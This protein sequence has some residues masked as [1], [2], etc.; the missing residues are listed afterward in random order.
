MP[1]GQPNGIASMSATAAL[2]RITSYA[3]AQ[4]S[5]HVAGTIVNGK[6]RIEL[7]VDA[8]RTSGQGSL[9][10]NGGRTDIRVVHGVLYDR[11][12]AKTL[13]AHGVP[14]RQAR[15]AAGKWNAERLTAGSS[16]AASTADLVLLPQLFAQVLKPSGTIV[17][18][19][20]V[21]LAGAAAYYLVDN[22]GSG[23]GRLYVPTSGDPL[24]VQLR[25]NGQG[26]TVTFT[27]Y[28][29]PL[30]VTAPAAATGA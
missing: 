1:S 25:T 15:A 5:V 22:G 12:D 20:T 10:E 28:G 13:E 21:Q 14:K 2:A 17:K 18:G 16:D 23:N 4:R 19:R 7:T 27:R 26:G 9:V 11:S 29:E 24:P 8:G 30:S 3:V 6:Q